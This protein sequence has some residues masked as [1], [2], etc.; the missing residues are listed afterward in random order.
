MQISD[1]CD[2]IVGIVFRFGGSEF[3][4][5]SAHPAAKPGQIVLLGPDGRIIQRFPERIDL[6]VRTVSCPCGLVLDRDVNAAINILRLGRSRWAL[7]S[8]MAGV[9]QEAAGL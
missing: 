1:V 6:S 5:T 2:L 3:V 7:T 8:A 4:W 9:A